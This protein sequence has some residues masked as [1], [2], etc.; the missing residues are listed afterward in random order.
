MRI[1]KLAVAGAL[2]GSIILLLLH[3]CYVLVNDKDDVSL[4]ALSNLARLQ[5]Q[6]TDKTNLE[7]L[8]LIS[9]DACDNMYSHAFFGKH[10]IIPAK[11]SPNFQTLQNLNISYSVWASHSLSYTL[12]NLDFCM[13]QENR[14]ELENCVFAN[15]ISFLKLL[16]S[17]DYLR[18][19]SDGSV[20]RFVRLYAMGADRKISYSTLVLRSS[21]TLYSALPLLNPA[22]GRY[23]NYWL[24]DF[25]RLPTAANTTFHYIWTRSRNQM[26]FSQTGLSNVVAN[27]IKNICGTETNNSVIVW[28]LSAD[29]DFMNFFETIKDRIR[30]NVN[31]IQESINYLNQPA[32]SDP[33]EISRRV[34]NIDR[35]NITLRKINVT[36]QAEGTPYGGVLET[37]VKQ[38]S[39][40]YLFF[41]HFTDL[42]RLCLLY[43]YGG[44]YLDTDI[45]VMRPVM[46]DKM[47]ISAE[48]YY[49]VSSPIYVPR[50]RHPCV[51]IA[52]ADQLT[53][54]QNYRRYCWGCVIMNVFYDL[55]DLMHVRDDFI[56]SES[57]AMY[58]QQ[59][60][61]IRASYVGNLY[62][63]RITDVFR[64]AQSPI[65]HLTP[66]RGRYSAICHKDTTNEILFN[67]YLEQN[68][69]CV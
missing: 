24:D 29:S 18:R 62:D 33:R 23:Y 42:F 37:F 5:L 41:T 55:A 4:R 54:L 17:S 53:K 12:D 20:S 61:S 14:I 28:Y 7:V 59:T 56:I 60:R 35:C 39:D 32:S 49:L 58:P 13:Q 64:E 47:I 19:R 10:I 27:S 69:E 31:N 67:D 8:V 50:A 68:I 34:T 11:C 43:R 30:A 6:R 21:V 51:E 65:M 25:R 48:S 16:W 22:L 26:L 66:M 15:D 40:S 44:W 36:E 3:S 1:C 2:Y 38:N 46:H 63:R 57:M 9:P 52:I 45:L